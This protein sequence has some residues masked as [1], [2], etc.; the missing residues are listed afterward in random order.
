MIEVVGFAAFATNVAGNLMLAG[1][2]AR[3]WVVRLVSIVLWFI[4]AANTSSPALVANAVTFFAINCYGLWKW[5]REAAAGIC[6]GCGQ[7]T[8]GTNRGEP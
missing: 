4:Y 6:G 8:L 7:R 1:K 2:S 3:G 5:K